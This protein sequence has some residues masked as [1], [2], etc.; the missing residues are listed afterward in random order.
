MNKKTKSI[1]DEVTAGIRN[2]QVDPA[3]VKQAADRVW[4]R[5]SIEAAESSELTS[6]MTTEHIES[7]ADFQSLIPSYLNNEL[8][9]A[10]SLLL[11][12]HTHECIPCR[13]AMKE[14]RTRSVAPKK[15]ATTVRRYSLQPVILRWGIAAALVIGFGL[16]AL[17]FIQRYAPFGGELEATV[18]AAEGQ[19][20]QIADTTTSPIIAGEKLQKGERVRTAKGAHALLRLGDGTTIEMR[21]RSELSVTRNAQ[22]TTIHLNRGDIMVEA[23]KQ[24][25]GALFVDTGDSL[26][27]VT[28][29]VFS[30]ANGTKGSRVSVVEGEVRVDHKGNE[31][32]I[33]AGEQI[34]TNPSIETIPVK[35]DVAWSRKAANYA[36]TLAALAGLNKDLSKVQQ[37]GV[38]NSTHLLDLMPENTVVYAALPNLTATIAESHRIMQERINQNPALRQ[39]YEK[40]RADHRGP[41]MDQVIGTVREFG[42][43]LGDEVAVSLSM[44]DKGEPDS[45]L[46]LAELKNSAGFRQFLEQQ[47]AKYGGNQ[48]GRENLRFVDDP[49]TATAATSEAGKKNDKL[50]VWINGDLF[51]ASPKLDQ[52]QSLAGVMQKGGGS[53]FKETAFY[54]RIAQVYKEGA[55]LVVAANLE[56]LI[57]KNKAELT[58]GDKS[59]DREGALKQLGILNLK[60]FALDQKETQGKTHTR[61]VLSFNDARGIPSW[62]AEPGP[63]GSL[64]YISPD[65]NVVAGFVV[66]NPVSLVDDLLGVVETVSPD[67]RKNLDKL[68]AERGLD[69][70]RDFAAPLGG[71]FAFAIDGPILPTPS[72]KMVFEV[73]DPQHLQQTLERVVM[74]VNKE[75][76]KFGKTG[77]VW[78][79]ADISGRTYYTL[80]SADFGVEVNMTYVNGY[81]VVGPSRALVER[82]VRSQEAGYSLLRSAKFTA[83]L[84]ADGNAN[85][86]ALFYHN[87]GPLVQPFADRIASS[88]DKL[89]QEQADAIK[90]MAAD[91]P[92]TLAYAYAQGDSITFA[93][94]TEGGPFGLSPASLLGMPNAL[95]I[96]HILSKGM[97]KN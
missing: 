76:A 18:Q 44:N 33:R 85:F 16:L 55:G 23:A 61:A 42:E 65:A 21:D 75:A 10:R 6:T 89:P 49:L 73:N 34:T 2:E 78:D 70:R 3:T 47:I 92:P 58:K 74:E 20:Y 17:P 71:E 53:P 14:A 37:P 81:M 15:A 43:Y 11:V 25:S 32:V 77:L 51:A 67:L 28:G 29:T 62:L 1:L 26:V 86:S 13:R 97:G 36:Q 30:V 45:P 91:M 90:K 59:E 50:Y 63:M 24:K 84:P 80:R 64:E 52:L 54:N 7:C 72:W 19:V 46:V 41:N 83:G 87:L 68:Q 40:E 93:A 4:A 60:H 8:S 82:A 35:D 9:E 22:G 66:K 88:A 48:Q 27:S 94:N 38:R 69:I 79:R 31:R 96:Q 95:E 39:W 5:L 57:E 56:Q 12:D